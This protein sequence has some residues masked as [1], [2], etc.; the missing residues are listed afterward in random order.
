MKKIPLEGGSR[1]KVAAADNIF[2]NPLKVVNKIFE[3]P[4]FM[5]N[6]SLLNRLIDNLRGVL[7]KLERRRAELLSKKK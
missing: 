5:D 6:V 1:I 4:H 3:K 2:T 7:T